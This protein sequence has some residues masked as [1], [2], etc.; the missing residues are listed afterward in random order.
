MFIS[1]RYQQNDHLANQK[2]TGGLLRRHGHKAEI[3]GNGAEAVAPYLTGHFD[4]DVQMPVMGGYEATRSIRSQ[5][6]TVRT[7]II[8]LTAKPVPRVRHG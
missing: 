4:V 6:S 5:E 8:G 2:V 3:A 7:P 1:Y